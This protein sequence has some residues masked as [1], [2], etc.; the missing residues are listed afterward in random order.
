[1]SNATDQT[2]RSWLEQQPS[3][4]RQALERAYTLCGLRGLLDLLT[5]SLNDLDTAILDVA[6]ARGEITDAQKAEALAGH[7]LKA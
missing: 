1:M 2:I 6:V 5:N 7:R 4:R 3:P